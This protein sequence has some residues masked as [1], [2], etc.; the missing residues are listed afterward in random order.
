MRFAIKK[1]LIYILLYIILTITIILFIIGYLYRF[2]NSL[3]NNKE[4]KL[5]EIDFE[6]FSTFIKMLPILLTW[7]IYVLALIILGFCLFNIKTHTRIMITYYTLI[8]CI[9]PFIQ[10]LFVYY[11]KDFGKN[12]KLFGIK[13]LYDIIHK[14]LM[15]V[16]NLL[17]I[18]IPLFC[19]N[20]LIPHYISIFSTYIR[21]L[22]LQ[23]ACRLLA[24]TILIYL[25]NIINYVCIQYF[26]D[27]IK[28]RILNISNE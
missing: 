17:I 8:L 22:S 24:L 11:S 20:F 25:F 1:G 21:N 9:L 26:V 15:P 5:P 23:L 27:T 2:S 18:V 19:I 12:T 7:G 10:V 13:A 14:T 6:S 4:I 3:Y 16:T 28:K